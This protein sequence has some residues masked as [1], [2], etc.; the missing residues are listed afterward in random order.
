MFKHLDFQT[1]LLPS[2]TN[3]SLGRK[4][5]AASDSSVAPYGTQ[6]RVLFV[7]AWKGTT[8][9]PIS[10]FAN[11]GKAVFMALLVGALFFQICPPGEPGDGADADDESTLDFTQR[12]GVLFFVLLNQT[13]GAL[14]LLVVLSDMARHMCFQIHLPPVFTLLT[15]SQ[16]V[17]KWLIS[18]LRK[19]YLLLGVY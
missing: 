11:L 1:T 8:R 6:L 19:R 2:T 7:R 16:P 10:S 17:C 15:D 9:N 5:G 4:H 18:Q 14:G 12:T 13:F 3:R